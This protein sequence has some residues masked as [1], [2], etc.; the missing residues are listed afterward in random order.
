MHSKLKTFKFMECLYKFYKKANEFPLNEGIIL[1]FYSTPEIVDSWNN[2]YDFV[3][4]IGYV[5]ASQIVFIRSRKAIG[6]IQLRSLSLIMHD[7]IKPI[8]QEWENKTPDELVSY[9]KNRFSTLY[10]V[11]RTKKMVQ[12][13]FPIDKVNEDGVIIK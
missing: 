4:S 5:I 13:Y 1:N 10:S 12:F 7:I 3:S 2:I 6:F 11:S 9:I 8:K